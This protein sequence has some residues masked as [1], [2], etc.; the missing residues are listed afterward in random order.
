MIDTKINAGLFL[1]P[2]HLHAIGSI[3]SQPQTILTHW[4]VVKVRDHD[5]KFSRHLM[6]RAN[7]EGRV[8]TDIV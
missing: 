2:G 8:S 6:G 5:G 1:I 4:Q 7:G 3:Q